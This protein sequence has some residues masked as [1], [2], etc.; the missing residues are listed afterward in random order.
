MLSKPGVFLF[1]PSELLTLSLLGTK[2]NILLKALPQIISLNNKEFLTML[3][4]LGIN[5]IEITFC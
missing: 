5:R 4:V 3:D 1:I 2:V